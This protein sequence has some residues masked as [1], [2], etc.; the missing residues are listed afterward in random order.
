MMNAAL[1]APASLIHAT[2]DCALQN[3]AGRL[4]TNCSA[5]INVCD[6][7]RNIKPSKRRP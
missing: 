2:V 7:S 1:E 6:I 5:H 3:C 4:V